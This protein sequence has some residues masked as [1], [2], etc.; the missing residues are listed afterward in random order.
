MVLSKP[1][2]LLTRRH[3]APCWGTVREQEASRCG[4]PCRR[5]PGYTMA[6]VVANKGEVAD[7]WAGGLEREEWLTGTL[8]RSC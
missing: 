5:L 1:E 6:S 2:L 7:W 8:G 3:E 4:G